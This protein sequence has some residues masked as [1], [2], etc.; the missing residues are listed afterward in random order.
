MLC[1]WV[2][3][4]RWLK[5]LPASF[6]FFSAMAFRSISRAAAAVRAYVY[7]ILRGKDLETEVFSEEIRIAQFGVLQ[8]A[9]TRVLNLQNWQDF[10]KVLLQAGYRSGSMITS[11]SNLIFAYILYLIGRT[12]YRVNERTLRRVLARWFF[13][14]SITG[15]YTN[16]PES[17]MEFDL[18]RFREI[19]DA[20]GFVATLEQMC[21]ESITQDYWAVVLPN[22]LATS[23]S[24]SPSLFAYH[25]ALNL[26][27]ARVLFSEQ[28]V[29]E[30]LDP[31]ANAR[32]N[33]LERHHLFPKGYL[34]SQGIT[35][36]R[37]TNQIAN[38]ALLEWG[39][40]ASIADQPPAS[41]LPT[42]KEHCTAK[43]LSAC[44]IITR[45]PTIGRPCLIMSSSWSGGNASLRLSG[46]P[47]SY[48]QLA[49]KRR[50]PSRPFL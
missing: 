37:D 3:A 38:Y 31:T 34:K 7:S 15:R 16:S 21:N 14:A 17:A 42:M 2:T 18:A 1:T 43:T 45:F 35:E 47:T 50:P 46:T 23:S 9:Q 49:P 26:L 13:M 44:T 25:A 8:E 27:D 33:A 12:E 29:A 22:E 39:D 40:N 28:K 30:L 11:K 19:K 41:Y 6:L 10:F 32:R 20:A 48:L 5:A 36:L 4:K 24:R